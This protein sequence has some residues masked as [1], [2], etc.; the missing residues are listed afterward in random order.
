M[1]VK[2]VSD[3]TSGRTVEGV[4]ITVL[5]RLVGQQCYNFTQLFALMGVINII[6]LSSVCFTHVCSVGAV[7]GA[8]D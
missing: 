2:V 1:N 5:S 7:E 6:P 3:L 4:E 8:F